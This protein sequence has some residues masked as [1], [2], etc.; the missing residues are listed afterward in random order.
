MT[1]DSTTELPRNTW[2]CK[3]WPGQK[4]SVLITFCWVKYVLD[5]HYKYLLHVLMSSSTSPCSDSVC[6]Q[7]PY[8]EYST[9][10]TV[11]IYS[12]YWE[13]STEDTVLR[14]W[15]STELLSVMRLRYS[16]YW[17]TATVLRY[18]QYWDW[19]TRGTEVLL[20]LRYYQHWMDILKYICVCIQRSWVLS[21]HRF[22]LSSVL[23]LF[24]CHKQKPCLTV[25]TLASLNRRT[26]P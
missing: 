21:V 12:Q 4:D 22:D 9:D 13:Y 16:C 18:S 14:Y 1:W 23:S 6:N 24:I 2:R 20:V 19:G 10:S 17:Y 11:L 5:I 7:S 3:T 25:F 15:H 8:L 26:T